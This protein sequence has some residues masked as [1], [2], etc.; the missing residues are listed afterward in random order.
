MFEKKKKEKKAMEVANAVK[1]NYSQRNLAVLNNDIMKRKIRLFLY[2][3]G[4]SS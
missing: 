4:Y 2:R 1:L 3:I